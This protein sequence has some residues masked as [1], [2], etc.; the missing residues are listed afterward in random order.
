VLPKE[1]LVDSLHEM[2]MIKSYGLE[3][4]LN[5]I[6]IRKHLSIKVVQ[7]PNVKNVFNQD[8]HGWWEGVRIIAT[9][10][11]NVLSVISPVEMYSQNVQMI[12]KLV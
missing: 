3:V 6:I 10:W 11:M 12:R 2:A 5:R 4:F 1:L 7:W 9:I 8:K